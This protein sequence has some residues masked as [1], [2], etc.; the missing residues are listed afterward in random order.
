MS[1][2]HSDRL[3]GLG[4][5]YSPLKTT[6][7]DVG[8]PGG[9]VPVHLDLETLRRLYHA[10]QLRFFKQWEGE[11]GEGYMKETNMVIEKMLPSA[12]SA[13]LEKN[14]RPVALLTAVSWKDCLDQPAD[15][16]TWVWI[17]NNL[18]K[19]ERYS[20]GEYFSRWLDQNSD[21]KV[22]C[23][24]NAFNVRSQKFFRRLGFAPEWF[25]VVR[26]K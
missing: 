8:L 5:S 1:N 20:I 9:I 6:G 14:G 17:D 2:I 25:H 7:A 15:W 18:S 23:F 26:S 10:T 19:A 13:A 24:I 16:V 4:Y 21:R 12:K 3:V 11:L 22:Q